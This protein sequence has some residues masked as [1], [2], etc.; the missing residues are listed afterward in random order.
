MTRHTLIVALALAATAACKRPQPGDPLPGLT[1]A[2]R[3]QFDSGRAV[4][5][6]TFTA[7][8][9]LGPLFNASGCGECHEDPVVGGVGDEVERHAA[10]FHP[11]RPHVFDR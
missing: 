2:Q 7:P 6:S 4:F 5:D 1:A 11:D 9:G 10:V 3:A 8:T